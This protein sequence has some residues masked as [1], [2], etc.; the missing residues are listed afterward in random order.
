MANPKA[1]E[2]W[3]VWKGTAWPWAWP[4]AQPWAQPSAQPSAH[5]LTD[6]AA[7]IPG[8]A[9]ASQWSCTAVPGCV[10]F[11]ECEELG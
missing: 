7:Q 10:S 4:L 1:V 3:V 9:P 2:K 5:P 11:L 8:T 6:T